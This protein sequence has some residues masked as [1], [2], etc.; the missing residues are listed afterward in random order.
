MATYSA[1]SRAS[2]EPNGGLFLPPNTTNN[3]HRALIIALA[4]RHRL[5]VAVVLAAAIVLLVYQVV[6]ASTAANLRQ[7]VALTS[8]SVGCSHLA[9]CLSGP[10]FE[11]MRE[12]AGL[13]KAEQPRNLGYMQLAK[14]GTPPG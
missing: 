12:C 9:R 13:T 6:F 1:I 11:R 7:C 3:V 4:A 8:K 10:A 5:A 14:R 2:R